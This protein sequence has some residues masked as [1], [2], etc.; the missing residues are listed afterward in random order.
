M[1]FAGYNAG[2]GRIRDW[3][4]ARGDPRDPN[5]DP[6]DWV[7]R[8]PFSETRNYVQR[9]IENLLVYRVRFD[10][11][12]GDGGREDRRAGGYAGDE[13]CARAGKRGTISSARRRTLCGL[14]ALM[15]YSLMHA[16]FLDRRHPQSC[17]NRDHQQAA[18]RRQQHAA[19]DDAGQRLLHLRADAGRDRRRDKA[20][21]GRQAG[22]EDLPHARL[23]GLDDGVLRVPMPSSMSRR[24]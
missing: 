17:Q 18:D 2:R 12:D 10:K 19:D 11:D 14:P 13:R 22:H 15:G 7:E 6:I 16:G 21:A 4:K 23:A 9:V 5:V 24:M 1:T 3:I 20:D 8:I